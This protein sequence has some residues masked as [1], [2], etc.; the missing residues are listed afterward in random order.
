MK[1]EMRFHYDGAWTRW[2]RHDEDLSGL[3]ALEIDMVEV[4]ETMT[5]AEFAQRFPDHTSIQSKP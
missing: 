5:R 3:V 1:C 2:F 4:S